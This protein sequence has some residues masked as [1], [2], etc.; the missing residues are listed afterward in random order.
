MTWN[1]LSSSRF[2]VKYKRLG[3]IFDDT[4]RSAFPANISLLK[5]YIGLLC[6]TVTF[7]YLKALN[8]TMSFTN[9]DLV[10]IPCIEESNKVSLVIGIVDSNITQSKADWDSYETS[11]DFKRHPLI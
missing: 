5:Y 8:P 4:S 1:K 9:G 6:S 7:E 2:A 11:W 3:Y 10:R